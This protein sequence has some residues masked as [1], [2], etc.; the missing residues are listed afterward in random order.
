MDFAAFRLS[1]DERRQL[2]AVQTECTVGWLNR[3]G[4]PVSAFLT[5]VFERDVFWVTSF[6]D[7]PRVA[8]L[9]ADP[10]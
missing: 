5:Y 8:C 7:R 3:D 1:D 9:V 6:R 4:W 10:R 2:L